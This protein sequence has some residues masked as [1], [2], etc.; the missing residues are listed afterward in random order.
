M[1]LYNQNK[2]CF[3]H[4]D[5]VTEVSKVSPNY[6]RMNAIHMGRGTVAFNHKKQKHGGPFDI[7]IL[8]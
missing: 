5:V 7:P 3:L 1:N 4:F 2:G 6:Q 8:I